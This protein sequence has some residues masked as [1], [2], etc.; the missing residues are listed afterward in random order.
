MLLVGL[1]AAVPYATANVLM[2]WAFAYSTGVV[3]K[4]L[5]LLPK[6]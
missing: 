5:A 1:F 6:R 4:D 2:I 3:R